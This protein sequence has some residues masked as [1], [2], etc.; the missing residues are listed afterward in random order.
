MPSPAARSCSFGVAREFAPP[1][2]AISSLG[3]LTGL[4]LQ[5]YRSPQGRGGMEKRQ[6]GQ[7]F[8]V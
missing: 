3:A 7:V 2:K 5:V 6:E 8:Q 4:Y 1:P